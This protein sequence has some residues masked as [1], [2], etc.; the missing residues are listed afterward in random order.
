MGITIIT[1][2]ITMILMKKYANK[3]D[4]NPIHNANK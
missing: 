1:D 3:S 2:M 4:D